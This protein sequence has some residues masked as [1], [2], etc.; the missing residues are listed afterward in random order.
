MEDMFN[1]VALRKRALRVYRSSPTGVLA[2]SKEIGVNYITFISF[3][4]GRK[5][6]SKRSLI[7]IEEWIEKKESELTAEEKEQI[8]LDK[9]IQRD[10]EVIEMMMR[11][12]KK[13][14]EERILAKN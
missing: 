2:V 8:R 5:R 14:K 7:A 10:E 11:V 6:T 13:N 9:E 3:L 1:R 4:N 12:Y